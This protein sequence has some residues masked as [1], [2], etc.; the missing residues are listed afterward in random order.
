M[1]SQ[2]ELMAP[3]TDIDGPEQWCSTFLP[4]EWI[5]RLLANHVTDAAVGA[6]IY[7]Q[8][9]TRPSLALELDIRADALGANCRDLAVSSSAIYHRETASSRTRPSDD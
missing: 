1:I 4:P 2:S 5:C 3:E 9:Q 6:S 8:A 7:E